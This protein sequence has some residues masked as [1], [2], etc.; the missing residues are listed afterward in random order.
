MINANG[1]TLHIRPVN[2]EKLSITTYLLDGASL[3]YT[4]TS[5]QIKLGKQTGLAKYRLYWQQKNQQTHKN[6]D[7]QQRQAQYSRLVGF[8]FKGSK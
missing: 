7:N 3:F 6:E 4:E 1:Q 5:H 8:E 2:K